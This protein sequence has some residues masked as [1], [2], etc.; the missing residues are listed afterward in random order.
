MSEL[1]V[2]EEGV[3][4]IIQMIRDANLYVNAQTH[5]KKGFSLSNEC[6]WK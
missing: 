3:Q 1:R 4:M 6:I 5:Q 2:P